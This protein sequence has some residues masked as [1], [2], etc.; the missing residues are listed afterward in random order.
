MKTQIIINKP[1]WTHQHVFK[2]KD[3]VIY[4]KEVIGYLFKC[5]CGHLIFYSIDGVE[6][7][8]WKLKELKYCQNY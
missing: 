2:H 1:E 8:S 6:L 4:H 7:P 5:F 3:D